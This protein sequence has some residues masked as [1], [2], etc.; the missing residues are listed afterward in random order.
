MTRF[1]SNYGGIGPFARGF[2]DV[3]PSEGYVDKDG[4]L[5]FVIGAGNLVVKDADGNTHAFNGLAANTRLTVDGL[6]GLVCTEIVAA[7]STV[8]S[9]R[10]YKTWL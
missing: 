9:A 3:T 6:I 4:F 5:V 1:G 7:G 2:Q 10:V 8:A